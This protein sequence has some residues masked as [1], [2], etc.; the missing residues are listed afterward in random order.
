MKSLSVGIFSVGTLA[1]AALAQAPGFWLT[2][3]APSATQGQVRALNLDGSVAAGFTSAPLIAYY[4]PGF[5]WTPQG[6]RY[7]FGLEPGMPPTSAALGLNSDGSVV[8]GGMTSGQ[9][10]RAFRRVGSGPLQDLGVLPNESHSIAYGVSGDGNTVVGASEHAVQGGVSGQAFRWTQGGG[11]QG[12]GYLRPSG[13][14]SQAYGISRDGSTIVGT[15][16]SGSAF[17]PLEAFRWT[18]S[19]GMQLLPLL[20]GAQVN[21]AEARAVN[22]TGTVIVGNSK[23]STAFTHAVRWTGSV[24]E[25]LAVA[26]PLHHSHAFAV[27]DTGSVIG[28][29]YQDGATLVAFVWTPTL[30]MTDLSSFLLMHGIGTPANY[31]LESVRAISGDG[32][33]FG[34]YGVNL[35]TNIREG[36][37]ATIPSPGTVVA[38]LLAPFAA[39]RRRRG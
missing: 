3:L 7:D 15:S 2:G 33:T 27:S 38:L 36:F 4:Q 39:A 35:T 29:T 37:V 14:S 1:G 19:S 24:V 32:L 11:M 17:D 20:P 8:A 6:G 34:G 26:M 31:R 25:D 12:L 30:G 21:E 23:N 13:Y 10:G 18:Q 22:A 16:Q 28:G 9:V 5:T